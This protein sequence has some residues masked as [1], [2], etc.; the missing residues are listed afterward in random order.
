MLLTHILTDV[1]NN[2]IIH[3]TLESSDHHQSPTPKHTT[4]VPQGV[5]AKN[6]RLEGK[7]KPQSEL[8]DWRK[9]NFYS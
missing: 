6:E 3:G 1:I 7:Q 8:R 2:R 5:S 9:Q 4:Y